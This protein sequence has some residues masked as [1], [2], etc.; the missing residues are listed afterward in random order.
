M[1]AMTRKELWQWELVGC[2]EMQVAAL[3]EKLRQVAAVDEW[4]MDLKMFEGT[5]QPSIK[6]APIDETL[7]DSVCLMAQFF[8]G[9]GVMLRGSIRYWSPSESYSQGGDVRLFRNIDECIAW[10]EDEKE[11]A[12]VCA[13]KLEEY[14]MGRKKAQTINL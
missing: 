10:L 8:M 9:G 5:L 11:A 12:K 4:L 6:A 7:F 3:R 14:W 13:E 2:C 1:E